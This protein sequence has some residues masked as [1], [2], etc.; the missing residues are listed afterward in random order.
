MERSELQDIRLRKAEAMREEG[1]DPY[2]PRAERTHTTAAARERFAA[3]EPELTDHASDAA[4]VV[5][6][7]RMVSRRHQ[8]K[9]VFAHLRD[10]SGELQLYIRRDDIGPE[11]FEQ[12]LKL[13]DLGDF[14]QARG[15]LFRTRMGE[16]SLR[17]A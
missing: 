15:H 14:V 1:I 9:T 11:A 10:G 3:I 7:G 16:I 13:Y 12:F 17:T 2:P 6:A 5:V 8:G 4:E